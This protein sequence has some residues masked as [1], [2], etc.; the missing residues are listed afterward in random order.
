MS[1]LRFVDATRPPSALRR[2][3]AALAT[4]RALLFV[5]RHL[6]WKL[7]PL[8]LRLTRGRFST[9]MLFGVRTAVLET[10]GARTGAPRRNA[11]IY[12]HDE[13]RV[14]IAASHGGNPRNP[15]WYYNVIAHPNV[16]FGGVP[17]RAALVPDGDRDRVWA[18]GDRVFPAFATYRRNASSLGRTIP[19]IQLTPIAG[20]APPED[21]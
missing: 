9:A 6:S 16:V 2:A 21:R 5:S 19:L 7:D 4:T 8:L 3:F 11:V 17:M 15:N 14:T 13:N 10:N 20:T 12:W 1:H 18:L